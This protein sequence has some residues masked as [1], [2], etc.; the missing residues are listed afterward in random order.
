MD[1]I[2]SNQI[3]NLNKSKEDEEKPQNNPPLFNPFKNIIVQEEES[4]TE[5]EN[6]GVCKLVLRKLI[7]DFGYDRVQDTIPK[8]N[9]YINSLLERPLDS[10]TKKYSIEI[11]Q[12]AMI[13]LKNEEIKNEQK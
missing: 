12:K 10:L 13:E 8:K 9:K 11:I 1:K 3:Y 4:N 6:I 2:L 7:K 5:E